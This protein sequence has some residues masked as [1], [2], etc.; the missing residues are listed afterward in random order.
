MKSTEF[1]KREERNVQALLDMLGHSIGR[2]NVGKDVPPYILKEIVEL[3]QIYI[4]GPHKMREDMILTSLQNELAEPPVVEYDEIHASLRKYEKFLFK[5]IDAYD[6]GY[7]GARAVFARYADQYLQVLTQY[8]RLE[9]EL[10]VELVGDRE[11]R[12]QEMLKQ[13]KK[14]KRNARRT[15]ERGIIR[16]ETIRNELGVVTA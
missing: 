2:M 10:L 9:S 6:L 8:I 3:L 7:N 13:F 12:D 16:M 11:E 15:S 14:I 4:Y 1:L 5:V